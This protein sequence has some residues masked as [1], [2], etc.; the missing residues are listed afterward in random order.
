MKPLEDAD[1]VETN[2]EN[3]Y[4]DSESFLADMENMEGV[5]EDFEDRYGE[6]DYISDTESMKR[7]IASQDSDADTSYNRQLKKNMARDDSED[8]DS[9][10]DEETDPFLLGFS[11]L[12]QKMSSAHARGGGDGFRC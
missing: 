6:H 1:A 8:S 10:D 7:M 9:S 2:E 11:G 4:E 5:V 12:L 3:D